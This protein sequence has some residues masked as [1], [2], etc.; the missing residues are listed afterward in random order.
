MFRVLCQNG[1]FVR[2]HAEGSDVLLPSGTNVP[3]RPQNNAEQAATA[4]RLGYGTDV[5][6]MCRDHDPLH[7]LLTDWLG[8]SSSYSLSL[9]TVKNPGSE[10]RYIA[11]AEEELV[12]ML[13]KFMRLVGLKLTDLRTVGNRHESIYW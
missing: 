4:E 2:S 13:Q 7:A 8:M 1:T 11:E 3:G 12:L 9:S 10:D 5:L 6:Q